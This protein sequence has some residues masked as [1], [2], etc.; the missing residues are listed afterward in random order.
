[1]KGQKHEPA[2]QDDWSRPNSRNQ[3]LFLITME[4]PQ[5]LKKNPPVEQALWRAG[6]EKS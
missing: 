1:M 2:S 6:G 4:P 5:T 3:W